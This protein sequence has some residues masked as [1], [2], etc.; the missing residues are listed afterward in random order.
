[1]IISKNNLKY[2]IDLKNRESNINIRNEKLEEIIP[3]NIQ[4]DISNS[5]I[6]FNHIKNNL[7]SAT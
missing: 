4:N 6:R 5:I 3:K 1:M 2:I 7:Y